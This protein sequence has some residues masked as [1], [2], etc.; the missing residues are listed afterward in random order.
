MHRFVGRGS[1]VPRHSIE[2]SSYW[3]GKS[4]WKYKSS[5][6]TFLWRQTMELLKYLSKDSATIPEIRRSNNTHEIDKFALP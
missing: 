1:M 6:S 4:T 3:I 2:K 5:K